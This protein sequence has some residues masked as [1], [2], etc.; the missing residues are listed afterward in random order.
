MLSEIGEQWSPNTEPARVAARAGERREVLSAPTMMMTIGISIIKVPQEDVYKRQVLDS[1]TFEVF[2]GGFGKYSHI[3][4]SAGTLSLIHIYIAK[5]DFDGMEISDKGRVFDLILPIVALIVFTV[6]AMLYTGG[7]FT[8][9]TSNI[10]EAFGNCDPFTSLVY[11]GFG[12][13]V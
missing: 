5:D 8:G 9:G 12:R 10:A 11:G 13:C 6:L 2:T 4:T 7:L 1:V 3:F